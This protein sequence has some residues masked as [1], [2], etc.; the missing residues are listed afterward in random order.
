MEG[1]VKKGE[2]GERKELKKRTAPEET[3]ARVQ[4]NAVYSWPVEFVE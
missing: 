4:E 1:L 3:C 2:G